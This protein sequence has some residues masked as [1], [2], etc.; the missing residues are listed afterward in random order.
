M[1]REATYRLSNRIVLPIG[2][3]MFHISLENRPHAI[4]CHEEI[5]HGPYSEDFDDVR[6]IIA[7][8]CDTLEELGVATFSVGGF[9]QAEWPVDVRYDLLTFVE[10]IGDVLTSMKKGNPTDLVFP[11]Q[12]SNGA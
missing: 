10:H 5:S 3:N 12:V 2:C 11:E 7:D 9:G 4:K 8:I 1:D 6:S